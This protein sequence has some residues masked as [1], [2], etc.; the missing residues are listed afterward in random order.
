MKIEQQLKLYTDA[1]KIQ[2]EE[3]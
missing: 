3:L 2:V 1:L